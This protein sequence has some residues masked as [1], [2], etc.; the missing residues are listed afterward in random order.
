M[1]DPRPVADINADMQDLWERFDD[2]ALEIA[3][4]VTDE[5]P[6]RLLVELLDLVGN[7]RESAD[8][9]A[10]HLHQHLMLQIER[11]GSVLV[12]GRLFA[13]ERSAPSRRG[14]DHAAVSRDSLARAATADGHVT[15]DMSTGEKV[16]DRAFQAGWDAARGLYGA[17]APKLAELRALGLDPDLY[18]TCST[19]SSRLTETATNVRAS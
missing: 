5:A 10:S 19:P 6:A 8:F 14:W 18:S 1:T 9:V 4:T 2:L 16:P 17:K 13:L 7:V 15:V 11:E 3:K 12:D